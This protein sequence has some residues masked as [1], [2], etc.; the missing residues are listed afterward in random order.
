ML[1]FLFSL[2][3]L[4]ANPFQLSAQANEG[5][6]LRFVSATANT[7][8]LVCIPIQYSGSDNILSIQTT[9]AWDATVLQFAGLGDTALPGFDE[10]AYNLK[11]EDRLLLSW[12]TQ[13]GFPQDIKDGG[14]LFEVCFQVVGK[15][16]Q[17]SD[18]RIPGD[19]TSTEVVDAA[20]YP[21]TV[22]IAA[23]KFIVGDGAAPISG[24]NIIDNGNASDPG[25]DPDRNA[26]QSKI[27]ISPNPSSGRFN[28]QVFGDEIQQISIHRA[29]GNKFFDKHFRLG[30]T[31][32]ETDFQ[33]LSPG[34]YTVRIYLK[35]SLVVKHWIVH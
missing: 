29:S 8:D 7:G 14:I 20:E 22:N 1:F 15:A 30:T 9:L 18:L 34:I 19:M 12:F 32:F 10:N 4:S 27:R 35:A 21:M 3:C 28:I 16:G 26:N 2:I 17:S 31:E 13:T 6:E 25:F 5:V 33:H 24:S 11:K 23:G